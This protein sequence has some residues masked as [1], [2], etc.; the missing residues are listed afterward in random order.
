MNIGLNIKQKREIYEITQAELANRT[1]FTRS[2]IALI[3]SGYRIPT[4]FQAVEI[5][6]HLHCSIDEL[7]NREIG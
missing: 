6:K 2:T 7:V 4:L 1:G 3:E 5:A